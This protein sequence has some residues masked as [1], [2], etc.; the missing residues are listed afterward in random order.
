MTSHTY[1]KSNTS[2]G[3]S[4]KSFLV[5]PSQSRILTPILRG[6]VRHGR[7]YRLLVY[8][9]HSSQGCQNT[10]APPARQAKNT[11]GGVSAS[12]VRCGTGMKEF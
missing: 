11:N 6:P 7:P 3:S 8:R 5:S 2:K 1:M 9:R 4:A 10:Q 12:C